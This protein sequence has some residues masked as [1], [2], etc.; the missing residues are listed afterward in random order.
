MD[1]VI[2][3]VIVAALLAVS[4]ALSFIP[5]VK[6]NGMFQL[7]WNVLKTLAGKTKN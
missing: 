4:E 7:V 2:F 6:A 5:R 1:P 3:G